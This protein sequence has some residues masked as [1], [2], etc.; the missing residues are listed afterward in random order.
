MNSTN[1]KQT[2][3]FT[4][5]N[6]FV[7][8]DQHQKSWDI[9]L[10]CEQD[11]LRNFNQPPSTESLINLLHRDYP[12][13]SY[14]CGYE[15]GLFGFWAQRELETAGIKCIVMH[16][17]D[18]PR[19]NK[20]KTIK[21]DSLDSKTIAQALA[22]GMAKPIHVPSIEIEQDRS[23]IRYRGRLQRDIT[24]IK[25]RISGL[26]FQFGIDLTEKY[27]K[28]WS[29]NFVNWLLELDQIKGSARITLNHMIEQLQ[30]LRGLLLKANRSVRM[31]QASEKYKTLMI[32]LMSVPGIGPLLA[33]TLIVEIENIKRFST[34]RQLNS[35]VG[36]YPM[37]YSSGEKDYK[38]SMTVRQ[39]KFLRG[40][41]IEAS[42]IAVRHDPALT[43]VFQDWKK[44]MTKKR[45]IVKV[46][47]K[48]LKRVRYVWMNDC[49]Y[50]LS[51]V[52]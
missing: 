16:A 15:A 44:R 39:N 10:F 23:L 1:L 25:N 3:D 14:L 7:G 47:R 13:A 46:A 32:L 24:R 28:S 35:F 4:N 36:L 31:L 17:A 48:L 5:K 11:Y 37:E 18:I 40:L 2:V 33:I 19:S 27:S 41:I 50:I 20:N 49:P 52:K 51:I 30:L 43:L 26:L 8:M 29:K 42:W 22:T 12:G 38:G 6:I 21:R 34:F 45:A 9:T